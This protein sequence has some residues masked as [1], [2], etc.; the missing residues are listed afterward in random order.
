MP[1]PYKKQTAH[2]TN[3]NIILASKSPRRAELLKKEGVE[4]I[5]IS[6]EISESEQTEN[7]DVRMLA[8][9]NALRKAESVS[10]QYPD[11]I[12]V[13]ADTIVIS[14]EGELFG[15]PDTEEDALRILS[16]LSGTTH[17]VVTG[18]ALIAASQKIRKTFMEETRVT[19][20]QMSGEDIRMYVAQNRPFD[21]AGSY[22]IQECGDAFVEKIDGDYSNVVGLPVE[23]TVAMIQQ[24]GGLD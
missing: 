13:G 21:K 15:K 12:V 14:S 7:S 8:I 22:A 1:C 24:I 18:V 11:S 17:S 4:F 16:A 3:M 2:L 6:P 19:M 9:E 10:T 5:Q 20:K 23:R